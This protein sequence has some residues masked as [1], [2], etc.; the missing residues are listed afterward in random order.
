MN[1]SSSIIAV[2]GVV[3]IG[4]IIYFAGNSSPVN[5]GAATIVATDTTALA[6]TTDLT[7]TTTV[8]VTVKEV[9]VDGKNYAFT[10][11]SIT[12]HQ[13]DTVK[14]SF[15]DDEGFHNLVVDGYDVKTETIKAG[16]ISSVQFV[17]DKAG[18]FAYYCSV[19]NHREKGMEGK[20]IVQ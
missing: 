19:G 11:S 8:A 7:A 5:Q 10:P 1:K 3:V 18:T 16:N 15:K 14:I 20:L 6:S 2:V 13:G 9:T 17:A 4:G 12:V